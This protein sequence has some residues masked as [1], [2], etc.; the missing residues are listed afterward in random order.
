[1]RKLVIAG[2]SWKQ[3]YRDINSITLT[4][5]QSVVNSSFKAYS[6]YLMDRIL[7]LQTKVYE[8]YCSIVTFPP[9]W[10]GISTKGILSFL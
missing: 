10:G 1:M 2:T 9:L 7:K 8:E 6:S 4:D 3:N 5:L